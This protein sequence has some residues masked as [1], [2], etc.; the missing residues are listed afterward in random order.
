MCH[1][2]SLLDK[3]VKAAEPT[4]TSLEQATNTTPTCRHSDSPGPIVTATAV[5][6]D[7]ATPASARAPS[8]VAC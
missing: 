3:G 1:A 5:R 6:P 7:A 4:P 8:T 2:L